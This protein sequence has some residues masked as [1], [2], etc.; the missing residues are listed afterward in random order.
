M[1]RPKINGYCTVT[2]CRNGAYARQLCR[3][4]YQRWETWGSATVWPKQPRNPRPVVHH[5]TCQCA[6]CKLRHQIRVGAEAL[7]SQ[8]AALAEQEEP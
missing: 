6:L 8:F 4:H 3:K 7:A 2:G 5:F 1:G